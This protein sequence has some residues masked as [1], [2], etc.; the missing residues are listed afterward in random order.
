MGA[1]SFYEEDPILALQTAA[2][3]I[4]D[5]KGRSDEL[6]PSN[7]GTAVCDSFRYGCIRLS[8]FARRLDE[9]VRA[10]GVWIAHD[11]HLLGQ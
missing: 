4:T 8:G 11:L 7:L 9:P 10:A 5:D 2:S 6:K 1:R 3:T